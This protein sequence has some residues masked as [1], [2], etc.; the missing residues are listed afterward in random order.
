MQHSE[1]GLGSAF[2]GHGDA[3]FKHTRRGFEKILFNS[4][5]VLAILFALSAILALIL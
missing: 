1:A 2:G 5:I 3:G 4:T